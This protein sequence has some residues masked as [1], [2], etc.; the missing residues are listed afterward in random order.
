MRVLVDLQSTALQ[1][2]R[3]LGP[4][5]RHLVSALTY[6]NLLIL[7]AKP[8]LP[9]IYLSGVRYKREP[10]EWPYECFD[11]IERC[12]ARGWGDCDDLA[13]WRCAELL[14]KGEKASIIVS[15]KPTELGKLY[16]VT[17]RRANGAKEDP[18]L[19]L[20]MRG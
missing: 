2:S 20:G 9:G 14:S 15:W 19:K 10:R 13:A 4:V 3:A 11:N 16:H 17:V 6:A 1:P 5:V 12:L 8:S 7:K 18:S